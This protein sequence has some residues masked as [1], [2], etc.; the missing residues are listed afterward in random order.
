M[1]TVSQ[2]PIKWGA[3]KGG[4][5]KIGY[6]AIKMDNGKVELRIYVATKKALTQNS[7]NLTIKVTSDSL[8]ESKNG[9]V[10]FQTLDNT[11]DWSSKNQKII[12]TSRE[13]PLDELK[14][15]VSLTGIKSIGDSTIVSV[16]GV[17]TH[18]TQP[19][20]PTNVFVSP[21]D[22]KLVITALKGSNGIN[23]PAIGMKI[24]FCYK[25]NGIWEKNTDETLKWNKWHEMTQINNTTSYTYNLSLETITDYQTVSA[26]DMQVITVGA[27]TKYPQY[28]NSKIFNVIS[29]SIKYYSS[30]GK[31]TNLQIIDKK[32]NRF[33]LSANKGVN[34]INNNATGVLLQ[35]SYDS[36]E[37]PA[38]DSTWYSVS[39]G[40]EVR[41]YSKKT[42]KMR[43][44]TIG[45]YT[46][47]NKKY[48]Y[49]YDGDKNCTY[50][51]DSM[52]IEYEVL[53]KL[54]DSEEN[55]V[56]K[57][58]YSTVYSAD[59]SVINFDK[60]TRKSI[61]KYEWNPWE[62]TDS[63]YSVE[64]YRVRIY[65]NGSTVKF[66]ENV[67]SYVY[68]DKTYY[69]LDTNDTSVTLDTSWF[70][71]NAHDQ[72][73]CTVYA[74]INDGIRTAYSE[75]PLESD[76]SVIQDL[77][78]MHYKKDENWKRYIVHYKKDTG[79]IETKDIYINNNNNWIERR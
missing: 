17:V 55:Y 19:G 69:Y 37:K 58:S 56:P 22:N 53:N 7:A 42:V 60:L 67:G 44:R 76:I 79:W 26:I 23:N 9:T 48:Y 65:V 5:I 34:G 24:R 74:K 18:Y 73:K 70:S 32:N 59:Y 4:Y 8:S 45:T 10:Y 41:I 1:A 50:L 43:A 11:K 35:Y 16:S 47:L 61:I 78:I 77:A 15:Q 3:I 40:E 38:S 13:Y 66:N 71:L 30:P 57:I 36:I 49:S 75:L 27:I 54:K 28:T 72:I 51:E 31:P 62:F 20:I 14:L 68:N 52:T 64:H 12:Y 63:N 46:G 29:C 39:Q 25:K 6:D 2:D 33:T 21:G